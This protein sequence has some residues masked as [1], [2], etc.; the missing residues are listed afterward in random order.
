MIIQKCTIHIYSDHFD[1]HSIPT[2][3]KKYTYWDASQVK[4]KGG[5]S[6]RYDSRDRKNVRSIQIY[7]FQSD[8]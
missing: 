4:R 1:C 7:R 8:K 2:F 3:Q 6:H 5:K